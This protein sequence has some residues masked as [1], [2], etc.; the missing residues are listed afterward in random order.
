MPGVLCRHETRAYR[1]A[2]I[3][4]LREGKAELD[5]NLCSHCMWVTLI[6][7]SDGQ[8]IVQITGEL[9]P[10][11]EDD[12][13]KIFNFLE[14]HRMSI[15]HILFKHIGMYLNEL[16]ELIRKLILQFFRFYADELYLALRTFK[17]SDC[18]NIYTMFHDEEDYTQLEGVLAMNEWSV[19]MP[20]APGSFLCIEKRHCIEGQ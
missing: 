16:V 6:I 7:R 4:K 17:M 18:A 8:V 20:E 5:K 13:N 3:Q 1:Q 15:D 10:R 2:C 19:S 9:H 14:E 12:I 11:Y